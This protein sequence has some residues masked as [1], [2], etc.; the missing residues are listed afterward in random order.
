MGTMFRI[1]AL[2]RLRNEARERPASGEFLARLLERSRPSITIS[3]RNGAATRELART[4]FPHDPLPQITEEDLGMLE[5]RTN[6]K[7]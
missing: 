5:R 1:M 7:Y 3:G 4:V 6:E 2:E